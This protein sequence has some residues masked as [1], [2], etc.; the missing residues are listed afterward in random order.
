MRGTAK[1]L[2]SVAWGF[3]LSFF[4]ERKM[5]DNYFYDNKHVLTSG[6]VNAA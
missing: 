3:S 6:L 2:L 5:G 4:T 1:S